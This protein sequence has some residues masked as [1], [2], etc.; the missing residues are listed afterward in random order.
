M[1]KKFN[2]NF[3]A[4]CSFLIIV[5]LVHPSSSSAQSIDLTGGVKNEY[6]Y[7]EYFFLTGKPIKFTGTNKNVS[8]N[9]TERQGKLTE[10]YKFTLTGPS[11]EKLTRNFT[12][13]YDVTNYDQVGQSSATGSVT[14]FTE[15]ITIG[16]RTFTLADYQLSK[17]TITDK[18]P[19]SDYYS[20]EAIARKTYTESTGRGKDAVT[21][22]ITVEASSRNEGY[23]NF[24]GATETQITDFEIVYEDG[25]I[26]TVKNKVSTAKSRT[27]DFNQSDATL[28][29]FNGNYKT[30]SS[31]DSLSEYEYDLP[32]GRG[33]VASSI[34]YMPKL[35]MLKIPKFR[36]LST[37]WAR[38]QIE[39]LYSLGILEDQSNFFSPNTPVQRLDFAIA[40][41]KAIDLRVLEEQNNRR[42]TSQPTIFKDVKRTTK[43]HNYLVAAVN[44][45]VIKGTT[46]NTFDPDG[47]LTR[48][49]AATI[50]VRA[51][52]LE[53]KAPDPGYTTD[54]KDDY[55]ITDYARDA[56]YVA[57]QLGLMSGSNGYFNP[58]DT[59]TR[60]QSS[61]IIERF[62]RYLENDLKENY[63]DNIL[64]FN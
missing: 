5:L 46:P 28:S 16:D 39:K 49:Q 19:A 6:E 14:K 12:Y 20:G 59:L 32:A 56:V 42:P 44:K 3:V 4:A 29:S 55:R 51:L 23:E 50:L 10:T 38:E 22:T 41:G 52:G 53:G 36:D 21:K 47:F 24:W 33:K 7:E 11:G 30:V 64:F 45:G 57:T 63:R 37:N 48:Q 35:E 1:R 60:A 54:Y 17:S 58:K 62:L 43:D 9:K 18:R 61:A 2:L 15:K 13:T 40:I 26:G 34:D 31:A 25:S 8:V 27:L